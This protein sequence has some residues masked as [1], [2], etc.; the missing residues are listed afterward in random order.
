MLLIKAI[1][2]YMTKI[3]NSCPLDK[4]LKNSVLTFLYFKG[5]Y[6]LQNIA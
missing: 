3:S 1:K 5:Q 4:Y 6:F 2:V